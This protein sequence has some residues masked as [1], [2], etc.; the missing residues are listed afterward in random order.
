MAQL[1]S[2][3]QDPPA[4]G[5]CPGALRSYLLPASLP[6]GASKLASLPSV[7]SGAPLPGAALLGN[8]WVM[9]P[10]EMTP[11]CLPACP[12]PHAPSPPLD[13]LGLFIC[14]LPFLHGR[15]PGRHR[16]LAL[17]WLSPQRQEHE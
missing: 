2:S 17:L 15:E 16:D 13:N 11:L 3:L 4:S 6:A 10:A 1:L 5:T 8:G 12:L 9:A 14:F 7:A